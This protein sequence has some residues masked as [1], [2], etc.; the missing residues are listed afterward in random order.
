MEFASGVS[1]GRRGVDAVDPW[2]G[3]TLWRRQSLRS[4]AECG[5]RD[6]VPE[7]SAGSLQRRLEQDARGIQRRRARRGCQQRRSAVLG[8]A[9]VRAEG[10]G[11][12][13]SPRLGPRFDA[14]DCA[15][16]SSAKSGGLERPGNFHER[17]THVVSARIQLP[18]RWLFL[19]LA[20]A[21]PLCLSARTDHK[22]DA[23]EQF[24]R[25]V[26]MRTTL[27]G[28]PQKE[29][30]LVDYR[31]A[32][33]AY[34]K[35]YLISAQAEEV[36]PSL[37]AEA[38][39]YEEMGRL[40]DAKYFQSAID[41]YNF[42]L[43]Q[44]PGSR[45]R[46]QALYSIGLVQ[47]D[48]LHQPDVAE[49]TLKD[50]IKRYP[51]SDLASD[52]RVA[53][54]DIADA[55][56]K[57]QA[58]AKAQALAQ[59]QASAQAQAAAQAKLQAQAKVQAAAATDALPELKGT[60]VEQRESENGTPRVRDVK[61]WNSENSA[62]IIVTLDDTIAFNAARIAAPDRVY[63]DLH[64][65]KLTPD[66]AKKNWDVKDGL[67]K[68]LRLGQN[69]D[70]VVR[71]VLD[72]SGARDY[73]AY[74]LANPYR[75]VIDVHAKPLASSASEVAN[76]AA[77]APSATTK[78]TKAD[79]ENPD[80]RSSAVAGETVSVSVESKGTP[81]TAKAAAATATPAAA[82][83]KADNSKTVALTPPPE[84][85]PT[86][87]GQR[88]LT[89]ALGLKISR[90][91]IDPGHGGHDTGTIGPHG[92]MEKDLCLDVALRLGH[93]IEEKLPGAEVIYTRKD[94]TFIPLEERTAIANDAKA[95]LFISVH[96]N[97]SHDAAARGIETYY[98]NFATSEESMAVASRENALAQSS[99]HDL[100]DIIKKIA[101]NEKVE[102]SK[103]LASDIQ[104]S[105]THR[106]Q[107]VSQD[108][109]NRGVKKAPFV[110]L[111]G[112]NMP[113]VLSEISFI[114]NPSDEKLLRKTD[115]RQRVADG[116]YRGIA[117]YLDSLNSL[118]Y[119]KSKLV[120]ANRPSGGGSAIVASDGNPK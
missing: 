77:P 10:A 110:V 65:A 83:S 31:A 21:V 8:N 54:K 15:K 19:A 14:L 106:L 68:S 96:A 23:R 95:D 16:K 9:T 86:R 24:E 72:V 40:F 17:M 108:E 71:L 28:T 22:M 56:E 63:F 94:D 62:R 105:L 41:S 79:S 113:S 102:E 59:A 25:A 33:S 66:I 36:T 69:K 18:A 52:A 44:Y 4:R 32:V 13:L 81:A 48:G 97:S 109:R 30:S 80:S 84:S 20:L 99:L 85:K 118:S 26:R 89:R 120:S 101:R 87:D 29:R 100:Q 114:S 55:R 78:S 27:E 111:I 1:Q 53:L 103:E 116:L 112:A 42:L 2:D 34:H 92:L 75:L 39:L 93:E 90:I 88:S 12:I 64:R 70:G 60:T 46:Q 58:Q 47:K 98:L 6:D 38:E 7:S 76:A 119:D 35:V 51:K 115:Q 37:I 67:L 82:K 5:R 107:L 74:L 49:A 117:S 50:Y 57:A 43:K 73:S 91:V 104:D 61:T 11:R 45:Y 3:T